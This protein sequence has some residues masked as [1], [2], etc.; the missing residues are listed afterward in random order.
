MDHF[1]AGQLADAA[2]A[3]ALA[4]PDG[5]G[6]SNLLEYATGSNPWRRDADIS[7]YGDSRTFAYP[8][9]TA[10]PGVVLWTEFSE[11]METWKRTGMTVEN[12][13]DD[14]RGDLVRV[15]VNPTKADLRSGFFRLRGSLTSYPE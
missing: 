12:S 5:D 14:Y 6:V 8:L 2:T 15:Y 9:S 13:G 11:N 4:D 1:N 3:G 7:F 10:A